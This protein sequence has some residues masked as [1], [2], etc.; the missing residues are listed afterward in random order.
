[1]IEKVYKR[2]LS[3]FII[4]A[5]I[6]GYT[7]GPIVTLAVKNIDQNETLGDLKSSLKEF[8]KKQQDNKNKKAKTQKEINANKEKVINTEK[9]LMQTKEN[10]SIIESQI[11]KTN[12]EIEKLKKDNEGLLVLYQKLQNENVYVSYVTGASTMTDL[13]MRL[14]AINQVTEYN[15]EQL[16]SLETLIKN[17]KKLSKKLDE[18]QGVLDKKIIASEALIDELQD[19]ITE[20]DEGAVS[21]ADEIKNLKEWIKIYEDMG[22]KDNQQLAACI[23]ATDNSKWLK[24]V[25]SGKITSLYG[26]RVAPT[27]GASTYHKGVD[28]GVAEGTK[29]YPT[30]NG[31]VAAV[32]YPT[33]GNRC[34]GKRLYIWTV[35]NGKKYTYVY[36]HLMEIK[37]KV[38]DNVT[39][40][41]VVA[42]SGGGPKANLTN[43]Y[44]DTC[45]TGA[46]LHYGLASDGWWG[47]NDSNYRLSYF[48]SHTMTPPGYPGLYQWFYSRS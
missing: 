25:T 2:V 34:G 35:V 40:N 31:V 5:I 3:V 45:T 29:V 42:L 28:I 11:E 9:E 21:I 14:D 10:I 7:T 8:E 43:A 15:K 33:A 32:V 47:S 27:K 18:Y 37:V 44:S 23:N 48:N 26:P 1:M 24:P 13:I 46:H 36:M 20:L 30:A 17:N 39:I 41:Q 12:E 6:I 4:I 38:G 16:N 19:E 22:C